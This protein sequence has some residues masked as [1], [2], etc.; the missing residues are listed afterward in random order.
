MDS[1]KPRLRPPLVPEPILRVPARA[2]LGDGDIGADRGGSGGTP[3]GGDGDEALV[4]E[5]N[6]VGVQAEPGEVQREGACVG[7]HLVVANVSHDS[8]FTTLLNLCS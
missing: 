3:N 6:E 8:R 2:A 1:R 4:H 7:S 5:G